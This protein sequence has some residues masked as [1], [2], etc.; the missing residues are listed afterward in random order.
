MLAIGSSRDALSRPLAIGL[1]T[2]GL[3]GLLVATVPGALS[4]SATTETV[5]S[6]VP[7]QVG[8][9]AAPSAGGSAAP[10]YAPMQVEAS[11]VP[12]LAAGG[13][14]P[15]VPITAGP[16][17]DGTADR[18]FGVAAPSIAPLALVSGAFVAVGVALFA[19]R[20]VVDA[21]GMVR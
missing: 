18:T 5:L 17:V 10:S 15:P 3:A 12:D 16:E 14:G 11:P 7:A 6:S 21:R 9:A 1:T 8:G 19:I 13:A 20:R 2:I 4:G